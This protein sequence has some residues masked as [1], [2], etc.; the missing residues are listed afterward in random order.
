V[1]G[2][3]RQAE[4]L[5]EDLRRTMRRLRR[6]LRRCPRCPAQ[7]ECSLLAAVNRQLDAALA[8]VLAEWDLPESEAEL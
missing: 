6:D 4:T 8:A 7:A 1:R 5:A 2:D 3:L